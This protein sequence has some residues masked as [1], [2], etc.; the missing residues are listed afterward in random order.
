MP[1]PHSITSLA[2]AS[3]VGGTP[4]PVRSFWLSTNPT[5]VA[6]LFASVRGGMPENGEM[7]ST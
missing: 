2:S 3:S 6:Q 7:I 5:P 1:T 4:G